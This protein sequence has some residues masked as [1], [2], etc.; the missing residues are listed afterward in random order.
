[1]THFVVKSVFSSLAAA[2]PRWGLRGTICFF[3]LI[4]AWSHWNIRPGGAADA[5][6]ADVIVDS[7]QKNY[8]ATI[9]FVADFRQETEVKTLNRNLKASGKLSFKR[10]GKMLWRYDEPKGQFVLADGKYLYFFQPEQ[11]QIIKS[12]LQNAFRSDIPLSFLLGIGN[13]KKDFNAALKSS[14]ENQFILRLEPKGEAGGFS[15]IL[16]GVSK[17]SYDILSISVRDAAAMTTIR[18]SAMRK[19]TGVKDSV[20]TLQIPNGAD[21]VELGQ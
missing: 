12:P 8:D 19:G 10:P 21:I 13:L 5:Q 3:F 17:H 16:A 6:S 11:N 20:F 7:V 14:D 9:D 2:Q 1:M 15:E 18:F 4:A